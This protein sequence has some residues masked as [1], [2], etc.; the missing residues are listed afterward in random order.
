MKKLKRALVAIPALLTLFYVV[1]FTSCTSLSHHS[2]APYD[3]DPTKAAEIEAAA[4]RWCE[5]HG[6]PAGTPSVPFR[7]DGCS[8]W[9]DGDYRD[10]CQT[11]DYAY[12]CGGSAEMRAA[13]DDT[14]RACVAERRGAAYGRLMWLGVRAGGHPVVPLYFRWGYGHAYSGCYPK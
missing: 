6:Q 4:A 12:W 13:A 8:W 9:P 3:R 14:L 11:H 5:E 2:V 1:A 10:C 7:F